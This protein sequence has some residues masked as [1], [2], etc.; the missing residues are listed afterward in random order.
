MGQWDTKERIMKECI[1]CQKEFTP[2]RKD[3]KY[4]SVSCKNEFH[5]NKS[6]VEL[7]ELSEVSEEN[8][9]SQT[10]PSVPNSVQ[11][12]ESVPTMGH[13]Q[14][15]IKEKH[16]QLELEIKSDQERIEQLYKLIDYIPE[17]IEKLEMDIISKTDEIRQQEDTIK[18]Q[19]V[20]FYNLFLNQRYIKEQ[21][22]GSSLHFYKC[23]FISKFS[24]EH[25]EIQE[26]KGLIEEN[27]NVSKR[28]INGLITTI[29]RLESDK[30]RLDE[31][32]KSVHTR[33]EHKNKR[34]MELDKL[35]FVPKP[36]VVTPKCKPLPKQKGTI[37]AGDLLNLEFETF[38][39]DGELGRF[40]GELDR[41]MTAIALTGDSGAGKSYF[42]FQMAKA[43]ADHGLTVKYFS[44]E[45]G[46]GR[47]TQQKIVKYNIHNELALSGEGTLKDVR[48]DAKLYDVIVVDSFSKLNAK[49][50]DFE[51]LRND[52]P[53][54]I[55]IIIFQKTTSGAIRGGSSILFNS[56]ATIDVH[57][58]DEVRV[59][60]MKKGRYGTIGW[61]YDI[62]GDGI[63]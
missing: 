17:K 61:V 52:F 48:R 3:A 12:V 6:K 47:L 14:E 9:V 62:E 15:L 63:L 2:N 41:N 59:A 7:E 18:I 22:S 53:K 50:P 28:I 56:S 10:V 23:T 32:L 27:I 24:D 58:K 29:K 43:F 40:L 55:F 19:D 35:I 13:P 25:E 26:M 30:K 49:A 21:Q 45:E 5:R 51:K 38:Q 36:K 60:T 1:N 37:G 4:C 46:I 8:E 11:V 57:F 16:E 34:L 31:M 44:L 42:S 54:T 33:L 20:E 39:L